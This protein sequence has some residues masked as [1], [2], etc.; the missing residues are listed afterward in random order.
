M[1][2]KLSVIGLI[3]LFI[4]A[5]SGLTYA[6]SVQPINNN[7][8][9]EKENIQIS[10]NIMSEDNFQQMIDYMRAKGYGDMADYMQSVGREGMWEMHRDIHGNDSLNNYVYGNNSCH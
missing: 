5:L 2:K 3:T 10:S 7:N 6:K 4:L 8:I 9:P 1:Y